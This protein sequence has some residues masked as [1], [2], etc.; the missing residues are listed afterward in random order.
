ML[1]FKLNKLCTFYRS[2]FDLNFETFKQ[3]YPGLTNSYQNWISKDTKISR[4]IL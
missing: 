3:N 1:Y 2:V 4:K